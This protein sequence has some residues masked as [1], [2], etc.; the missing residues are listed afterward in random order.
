MTAMKKGKRT[1]AVRPEKPIAPRSK[2][3]VTGKDRGFPGKCPSCG[4]PVGGRPKMCP[5]CG[6][7]LDPGAIRRV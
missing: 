5:S 7:V 2:R 1:A 6:A 4:K 3:P